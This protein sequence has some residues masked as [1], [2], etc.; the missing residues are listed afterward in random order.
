MR[1][2]ASAGGCLSEA[3]FACAACAVASALRAVRALALLRHLATCCAPAD[4]SLCP[5][6][7]PPFALPRRLDCGLHPAYVGVSSLP[8]FDEIDPA[9]I[10]LLL[11][12]HFHLDHAAALPYFLTKTEFKGQ[13][14]HTHTHSTNVTVVPP[15]ATNHE[16]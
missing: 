4:P 12:T 7:R 1:P 10:D 2:S 8:F 6:V 3:G 9:A 16:H 14:A 15:S 13:H 5:C 11:V